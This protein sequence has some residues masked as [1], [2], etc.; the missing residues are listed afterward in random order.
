MSALVGQGYAPFSGVER[1]AVVRGGG[2]GD[3]VM[4]MP[5]INALAQTYPQAHITLLGMPAHAAIL[6]HRRS[7]IATVDVLP[8]AEG[9]RVQ[10]GSEPTEAALTGFVR[11]MRRKSFDLAVQLHGGG[12]FSNPFVSSLHASHTV[13][14]RAADAGPLERTVPH[15]YFQHEIMRGLDVVALAGARAVTQELNWQATEGELARARA[16]L[17]ATAPIRPLVLL[18]PGA[19]DPRRRWSADNFA[20]VAAALVVKGCHLLVV[21]DA[22][23]AALAQQ[24]VASGRKL[25]PAGSPP[26]LL[27][28]VAGAMDLGTFCGL[29]RLC[30][31]LVANDSGPRHVA[32]ALGVATAA[33]FWAPNMVN[34]GPLQRARHRVQIAWDTRC[35]ECSSPAAGHVAPV[36]GHGTSFVNE[37]PVAAVLDDALELLG[38]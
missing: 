37:V 23:E 25:L 20:A 32:Q 35:P 34:A 33:V 17:G 1:I 9:I 14:S 6:E 8:L 10:P 13:G 19:Q 28:S 18:H 12:K 22:S 36:C 2:I 5:A 3:L 29:L 30:Q 11:S 4:A 31:V 7:A 16:F 27:Q 15:Q 26:A 21:G 38:L 24:V